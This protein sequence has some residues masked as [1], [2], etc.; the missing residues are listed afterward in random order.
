MR[1]SRHCRRLPPLARMIKYPS[2]GCLLD[3]V[4]S[5]RCGGRNQMMVGAL[6]RAGRQTDG[7]C[8]FRMELA[9]DI[10]A[11]FFSVS[12]CR[13][14]PVARL[15][16]RLGL[17]SLAPFASCLQLQLCLR[18]IQLHHP[19]RAPRSTGLTDRMGLRRLWLCFHSLLSRSFIEHRRFPVWLVAQIHSDISLACNLCNLLLHAVVKHK[20]FNFHLTSPPPSHLPSDNNRHTLFPIS[21]QQIYIPCRKISVI[22]ACT[23]LP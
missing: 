12:G 5:L 23:A 21:Y 14:S 1:A 8:F 4:S 13:R 3:C 18:I 2:S 10:Y 11:S 20:H 15:A 19:P 16:C 22:L 6:R 9:L 7:F 17:L